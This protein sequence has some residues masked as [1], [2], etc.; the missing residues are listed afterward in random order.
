[1]VKNP[2]ASAGDIRDAVDLC[3]GK[4]SWRRAWQP[5]PVRLFRESPWTDEPG[6]LQSIGSQR[7]GQD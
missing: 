7:V 6:R 4:I 2:P 3:I 5:T 1:M